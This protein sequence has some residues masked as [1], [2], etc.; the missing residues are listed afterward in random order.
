MHLGQSRAQALECEQER[1]EEK[2]AEP[3]SI[4]AWFADSNIEE[5]VALWIPIDRWPYTLTIGIRCA[6]SFAG[7]VSY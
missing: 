6:C 3:D 2:R 5:A 7:F 4:F 1:S